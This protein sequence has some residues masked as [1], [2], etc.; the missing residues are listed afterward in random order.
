MTIEI[1]G[2]ADE[3]TRITEIN[4]RKALT[5]LDLKADV[6][7]ITDVEEMSR[8]CVLM[9]PEIVVD[10]EVESSGRIPS[11]AAARS[12]LSARACVD[13]VLSSVRNAS[14]TPASLEEYSAHETLMDGRPVLIRAI[15][16][17]DKQT[18]L[19]GFHRLSRRSIY[20]RFHTGKRELTKKELRYFTEID[21]THHVALVAFHRRDDGKEE[22]IGVG[23]YVEGCPPAPIRRAEI[24][25]VVAD[26][27]QGLGVGSLLLRHLVSIGRANGIAKFEADILAENRMMFNLV[28]HSGFDMKQSIDAGIVHVAFPITTGPSAEAGRGDR[29][30]ATP[31]PR[32]VRVA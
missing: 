26:S 22:L 10:G 23:R 8:R 29:P 28:A 2:H 3:S 5:E 31:A 19:N 32:R 18:L 15:R 16:P 12:L 20:L 17:E 14:R 30:N 7:R 4:I 13:R 27:F 1:F 24:A 25:F 9:A 11:V 21:F 6:T